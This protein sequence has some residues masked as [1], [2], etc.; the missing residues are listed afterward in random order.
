MSLDVD[1]SPVGRVLLDTALPESSADWPEI[2]VTLKEDGTRDPAKV[3]SIRLVARPV[4]GPSFRRGDSN[5]D[6]IADLSDA[7]GVLLFLFEGGAD[8]PCPGAADCDD[9]GALDLSDPIALLECLFQGT[10]PLPAPFPDC[11][12]DPSLDALGCP[13]TCA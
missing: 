2:S 5:A 12:P 8:M 11:G 13:A 9:S 1:V 7:V 10:G 6:G 3:F 4:Y